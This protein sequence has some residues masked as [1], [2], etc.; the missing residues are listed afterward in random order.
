MYQRHNLLWF[1]LSILLTAAVLGVFTV[2][3]RKKLLNI[4]SRILALLPWLMT[5]QV[6]LLF[7]VGAYDNWRLRA[8]LRQVSERG[9]MALSWE[10]GQITITNQAA[11]SNLVS[12]IQTVKRGAAHH[13]HPL[14]YHDIT[15]EFNGQRFHYRLGQDSQRADEYWVFRAATLGN[16]AKPDLEIGRIHSHDLTRLLDELPKLSSPD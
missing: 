11:I 13:S 14:S 1:V 7:G 5:L 8:E 15:F 12:L 10:G 4:P 6:V 2:L 9:V 3:Q 16:Q